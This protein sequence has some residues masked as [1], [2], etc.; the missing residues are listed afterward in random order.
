[1][2]EYKL[3]RS[4]RKTIG[5]EIKD[6]ELIVRAPYKAAQADIDRVLVK[7]GEWINKHLALSAAEKEKRLPPLTDGE[8]RALAEKALAVIPGRVR[9]FA[10]IVG[11]EYGRITIRNQRTKWGSC[12]GKGNLNFN[13]LL[14]LAPPETLDAVVVHEL[15][16]LKYMNHSPQFYAEV[17]RVLPDYRTREK[18]LKENGAALMSRL[19]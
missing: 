19:G 5:I 15:C 7:S 12:S 1:M 8:V 6:G 14:M 4:G 3:V 17:T 16:H 11:V 18:W 9:H 2:F 10:P 13:C